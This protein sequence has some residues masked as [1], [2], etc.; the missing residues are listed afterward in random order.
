[1][2]ED[3][4][5]G[6]KVEFSSWWMVVVA[7]LVVTAGIFGIVNAFGMWGR[8]VV[9]REVLTHSHQYREARSSEVSTYEAQLAE[10]RGRLG[11]EDLTDSQRRE[12]EALISSITI[13]L[14]AARS[15]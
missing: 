11:R 6:E 8:T 3:E 14:S 13:Q 5:L 9:E 7:L 10:L 15:R 2:F 1:M 12:I 4:D